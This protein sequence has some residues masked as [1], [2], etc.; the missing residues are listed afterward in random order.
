MSSLIQPQR[1]AEQLMRRERARVING[2]KDTTSVCECGMYLIHLR[3]FI[4]RSCLNF[5]LLLL[6]DKMQ[7]QR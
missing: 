6:L 7:P 5:C 3:I 4:G 2:R 1:R